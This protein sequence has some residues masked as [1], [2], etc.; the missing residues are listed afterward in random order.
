MTF[1]LAPLLAAIVTPPGGDSE[2]RLYLFNRW[3]VQPT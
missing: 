3:L 2:Y 1:V